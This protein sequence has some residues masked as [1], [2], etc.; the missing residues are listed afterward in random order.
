MFV[1]SN[2]FWDSHRQE[3]NRNTS[4]SLWA[5]TDWNTLSLP[6]LFE[7]HETGQKKQRVTKFVW[8][9][10]GRRARC[11][12]SV[13]GHAATMSWSHT[14]NFSHWGTVKHTKKDIIGLFI[15]I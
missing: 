12:H 13:S 6:Y 3:V 10:H 15:N 2:I 5:S 11:V 14:N 1:E 7:Q 8:D 9:M 4:L